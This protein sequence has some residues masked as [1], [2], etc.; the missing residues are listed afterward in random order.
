MCRLDDGGDRFELCTT[1]IVAHAR[2]L[3]RC[4]ECGRSI[5]V[6]ASY[7]CTR[8]LFEGSWSN[9]AH[10]PWCWWAAEWLLE[11]CGGFLYYGD[12]IREELLE[13]WEGEFGEPI[14]SLALGR[15]I[16]A[17]RRGYRRFFAPGLMALPP[18]RVG[19]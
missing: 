15:R 18:L 2:R 19:V 9:H 6:G 14:R 4:I 7:V 8:A 16:V 17:M 11:E 5:E 3:H 12:Q 1:V 13:H 10:C